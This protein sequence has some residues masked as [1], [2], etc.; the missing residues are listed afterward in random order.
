MMDGERP[1]L[2]GP[3]GAG[4]RQDNPLRRRA[5]AKSIAGAILAGADSRLRPDWLAFAKN[6]SE[7]AAQA[8]LMWRCH[9]PSVPPGSVHTFSV[10]DR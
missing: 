8:V 2:E 7:T 1:P 10:P 9:C 4:I 6:F 3:D 5:S